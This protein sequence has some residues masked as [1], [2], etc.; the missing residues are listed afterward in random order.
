MRRSGMSPSPQVAA[1]WSVLDEIESLSGKC[2]PPTPQIRHPPAISPET[3]NRAVGF[4][5]AIHRRGIQLPDL[6]AATHNGAILLGWHGERDKR[7]ASLQIYQ[8]GDVRCKIEGKVSANTAD[9]MWSLVAATNLLRVPLH[10]GAP[11]AEEAEHP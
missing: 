7:V 3:A 11:P 5:R 10:Q 4:V 2:P 1:L 9:A 8:S 6:L